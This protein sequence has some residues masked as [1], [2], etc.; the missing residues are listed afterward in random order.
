MQKVNLEKDPR[1]T[2]RLLS[3]QRGDPC[4]RE[5]LVGERG[6]GVCGARKGLGHGPL[7]IVR[8][9]C[10]EDDEDWSWHN[11]VG[12]LMESK[13]IL[14][15]TAGFSGVNSGSWGVNSGTAG[16]SGGKFRIDPAS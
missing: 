14:V 13:I 15:V 11:R 5:L 2:G 9:P 8:P 12:R 6:T 16:F 4:T 3:S 10:Y 7:N 1:S